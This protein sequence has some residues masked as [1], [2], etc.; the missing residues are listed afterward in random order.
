MQSLFDY[1]LPGTLPGN[2]A[3]VWSNRTLQPLA[4]GPL[5]PFS[6]TVLAEIIRRAWVAYYDQLGF[7]PP[8]RGNVV[9]GYQGRAYFNLSLSAKIEA[10]QAGVAPLM[11]RVNGAPLPLAAWEKPGLL[12][13]FKLGRAQKKIDEQLDGLGRKLE[14]ITQRAQTWQIRTQ[15]ARWSQAEVLQV[16]EEIEQAGRDSM[17]AFLAARHQLTSLY[18]RLLAAGA[19]GQEPRQTLLL[20]NSALAG[21]TGLVESEMAAA[22]ADIGEQ[23][24]D[25]G[26]VVAWLR[27]GDYQNWRTE[28]P[29]RAAAN[30]LMDFFT[31]YGHRG[32]GEGELANPRWY[33]DPSLVMRNLL[34]CV[35]HRA[36]RPAK[37]PADDYTQKALDALQPSARKEGMQLL[38]RLRAMHTLQSRSL[39]ALAYILAGTRR[40]A[41]AAAQEAMSDQRL[42]S[43]DQIFFFELEEIKQMMT[44]EWNVSAQDEIRATLAQRQTEHA[45]HQARYPSDLLIGDQEAQPVR[46][47]LPGAAGQAGGPLCRWAASHE[48]GCHHAILGGEILD[49]GWALALP[50]ADGFVAA[51]GSPLDPLVAAARVWQRPVVVGL[52]DTYRKLVDGAQTTLDGDNATVSQ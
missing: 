32:M 12:G 45:A 35:E 48:N 4:A 52:G 6:F 31:R 50:V 16:M 36:S 9:R 21:L 27:A 47:G 19:A 22:L 43:P 51:Q 25:T 33:E 34:A 3:A 8:A 42:L 30:T 23:V 39:H 14:T 29:D 11:L 46:A 20:L 37:L 1:T 24:Q 26:A 38:E 13:G 44:G 17:L 2:S 28:F 5:T 49:S 18:A 10:E 40:W 7:A 15:E 41:L